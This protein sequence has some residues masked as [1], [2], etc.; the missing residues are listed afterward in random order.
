MT[1]YATIEEQYECY[2]CGISCAR[3]E[4]INDASCP[5]CGVDFMTFTN[6]DGRFISLRLVITREPMDRRTYDG[7][8]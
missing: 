3:R 2:Q 7:R 8:L 1:K 5:N 4:L 6:S